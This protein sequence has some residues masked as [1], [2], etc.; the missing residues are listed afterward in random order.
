MGLL[1]RIFRRS[2]LERRSA[3]TSWDLLAA[4]GLSTRAGVAVNAGA[5]EKLS[6]AFASVQLISQTLA[7][8][9]VIIYRRDASGARFEDRRHPVARLFAGDINENQT[10]A[11]FFE[12]MQAAVLWHGNAYCEIVRNAAGQPVELIPYAPPMVSVLRLPGRRLVY[13]ASDVDGRTRRLLASEMLHLR[14]RSTDGLVGISRL[15][16]ARESFSTAIATENFASSTFKNGARLSGILQHPEALGQEAQKN[17]KTTFKKHYSGA[18]NAGE[19]LVLEEGMT[20]KPVSV[21]PEAAELLQSRRFTV[22][23]VA[24]LF[25]VPAQLIGDTSQTNFSN[26]V[27]ASRHFARFTLVPWA[28]RWEQTLARSL[29]GGADR[30]THE[31]EINLDELLRGDPLQR[32]QTWRVLREIGAVNANEIRALEGWNPRTDPAGDEFL[33]PLNMMPEQKAAPKN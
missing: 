3:P 16:R 17:L 11:D 2:E 13:D 9:P 12:L 24:R 32:A 6:A 5:A 29:L 15:L 27:E 14:D 20:F 18:K 25:G 22:E 23:S 7:S 8:M 4:D 28:V 19:V 31:I 1:A 30:A 26:F 10:A 21:P 33:A